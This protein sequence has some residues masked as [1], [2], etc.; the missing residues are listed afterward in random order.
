MPEPSKSA[1]IWALLRSAGRTPS[2]H[3]VRDPLKRDS[4]GRNRELVVTMCVLTAFGLWLLLSLDDPGEIRLELQTTVANQPEDIAFGEIPATSVMA[5]VQGD[6]LTLFKLRFRPPPFVIDASQDVIDSQAAVDWPQGIV[7]IFDSPQI[8]LIREGRTQRKVPIRS[9]VSIQ[10]ATGYSLFDDPTVTPDSVTIAG[11]ASIVAGIDAWPTVSVR[12]V[13]IKDSLSF[14]VSLLDSL[15]GL[16]MLSHERIMLLAQAHKF[17]E[18]IRELRVVVTDIPNSENVVD[19]DPPSVEVIFHAP[20]D[21]F[22]SVREAEGFY[23]TVSYEAIR[24]DT[25]G[26]VVPE[27]TLPADLLV[28][29]MGTHPLSLNYYVNTGVQ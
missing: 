22:D 5:S 29:H 14:E 3:P 21:Q 9:R 25:T 27:I 15:T 6:V 16:V 1:G 10:P 11:A 4:N 20:L 18:G 13:G 7:A 26:S 8:T 19:L 2:D 24:L 17:T 23:A 28:R 12:R